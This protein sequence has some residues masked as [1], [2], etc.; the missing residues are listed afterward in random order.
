M[1]GQIEKGFNMHFSDGIKMGGGA[2][3][4][5]TCFIFTIYIES[6]DCRS[7]NEVIKSSKLNFVRLPGSE[8]VHK[9][10]A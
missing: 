8:K 9:T 1:V 6:I 4:I 5:K 3:K 2:S 10:G 7:G